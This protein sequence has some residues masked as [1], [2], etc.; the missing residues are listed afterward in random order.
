MVNKFTC[1][2]K[3]EA[4]EGDLVFL[5]HMILGGRRWGGAGEGRPFRGNLIVKIPTG[6]QILSGTGSK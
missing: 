3:T 2:H 5:Q 6:F 4:T 1:I